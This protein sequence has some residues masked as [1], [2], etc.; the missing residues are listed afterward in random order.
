MADLVWLHED[1]LRRTH[2]VFMAAQFQHGNDPQPIFIWD[3]DYFAEN[4]IGLKRQHFIYET[5]I[6][7]G[8]EIH[9]GSIQEVL[10][11]LMTARRISRVLVPSTPNPIMLRHFGQMRH[12]LPEISFDMIDETPFAILSKPADLGRFFR[13]WNKARKSAMRPHGG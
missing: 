6:E 12:A 8:A 5:L 4:G 11:R 9:A 1:A 2:P 7:L 3:V 13:Y 10:P